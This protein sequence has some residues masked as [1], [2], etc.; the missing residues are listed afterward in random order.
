MC[1]SA[2]AVRVFLSYILW[3]MNPLIRR[4]IF[5]KYQVAKYKL[6]LS[7]WISAFDTCWCS[8]WL[9]S[10]SGSHRCTHSWRPSECK[11]YLC[12]RTVP[13]RSLPHSPQCRP[14]QCGHSQSPTRCQCCYTPLYAGDLQSAARTC[15]K[16]RKGVMV[17]GNGMFI[18]TGL[19]SEVFLHLVAGSGVRHGL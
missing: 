14:R 10:T 1:P 16:S 8:Q 3:S 15:T 9:G 19:L 2:A 11:C 13:G 4:I 12:C 18:Y 17:N 5:H 7:T 6:L